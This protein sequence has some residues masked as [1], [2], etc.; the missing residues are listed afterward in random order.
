VVLQNYNWPGNV[1]ELENAMQQA[2]IM[3]DGRQ[4]MP[5]HLPAHLRHETSL[6]DMGEI[7]PSGSFERQLRE[8]K[9]RLAEAAI[10]EHNGNKTL[11][12]RS[13]SISRAYLHRLIRSAE[14]AGV[15]LA[16]EAAEPVP[17][18]RYN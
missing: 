3:A 15:F 18:S 8:Y 10:R 7:L 2:V 12:A 13:L 11:A 6:V 5:A 9:V 16:A 1:R 17:A 14:P 4:I